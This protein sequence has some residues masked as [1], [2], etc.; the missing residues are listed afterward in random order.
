MLERRIKMTDIKSPYNRLFKGKAYYV[1]KF[2]DHKDTAKKIAE[3]YRKRGDV[4]RVLKHKNKY[5]GVQY[6]VYIGDRKNK[7]K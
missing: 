3:G 5:S 1:V 4:A 6:R 7:S 2:C